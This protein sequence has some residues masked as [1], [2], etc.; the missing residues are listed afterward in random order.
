MD[1]MNRIEKA[2]PPLLGWAAEPTKPDGW[3]STHPI[4]AELV[5]PLFAPVI[6]EV[7]TWHGK[8]AI[9]MAKHMHGQGN[10][11]CV[12]TWLGALEFWT[13][14]RDTPERDL[15]LRSGYPQVFYHFLA[16][17]RDAGVQDLITPVPMPSVMGARYLQWANVSA[18]LIY[19][20]ASHEYEDVKA[21][22]EAY[23]PLLKSG[24]TMF[25]DDFSAFEGVSRAVR[26]T[27]GRNV[28]IVDDNFWVFQKQ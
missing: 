27:F 11:Y 17:I 2:Q 23:M 6:I 28:R 1:E 14:H 21:D 20:D 24:C 16:C 12:D 4:F 26:E 18:D 5:S 10:I 7:G 9:E 13:T 22:I 15:Q 19:I 8:S 25:G 3:N